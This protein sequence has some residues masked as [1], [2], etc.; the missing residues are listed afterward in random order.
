MSTDCVTVDCATVTCVEID[1]DPPVV[2][3]DDGNVVTVTV[4]SSCVSD[5]SIVVNGEL[6]GCAAGGAQNTLEMIGCC[7]RP[8]WTSI[9][10]VGHSGVATISD[11]N[12]NPTTFTV[13]EGG[14][15]EF[16]YKC[17]ENE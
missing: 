4:G 10:A 16:A 14:A 17:W 2:G 7:G 6:N 8:V 9:T 13:T 3:C 11:V 5:I 12:A 15:Y 1:V